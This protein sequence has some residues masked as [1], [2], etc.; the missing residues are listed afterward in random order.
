ML[1]HC[2]WWIKKIFFCFLIFFLVLCW[3]SFGEENG[4]PLQYSCLDNPMDRGAWW[5]AVHGVAKSRSQLSD[6]HMWASLGQCLFTLILHFKF[7]P[8]FRVMINIDEYYRYFFLPCSF[9]IKW[10]GT[11][12]Y[13]TLLYLSNSLTFD[14]LKTVWSNN[15]Y[16]TWLSNKLILIK[17]T[18]LNS[19]F[20][21]KTIKN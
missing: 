4:N 6:W 17:P 8:K 12:I 18:L 1:I 2:L 21:F 10:V 9:W 5:A 19:Y 3:A 7:F 11:T 20:C 14:P 15:I 16:Y 13:S